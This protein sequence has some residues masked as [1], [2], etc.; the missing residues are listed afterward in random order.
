MIDSHV[1][2]SVLYYIHCFNNQSKLRRKERHL[3]SGKGAAELQLEPTAFQSKI[4]AGNHQA[5]L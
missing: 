1:Y 4:F 2:V 3:A 5:D